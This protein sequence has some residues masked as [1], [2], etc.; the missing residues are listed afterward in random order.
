M[1]IKKITTPDWEK[2]LP[3]LTDR[4]DGSF[5]IKHY[6]RFDLIGLPGLMAV[7]DDA[8]L[9]VL[10]WSDGDGEIELLTLDAL[11]PGQGVGGTLIDAF[12]ADA[13]GSGVRRV[14]ATVTNDQLTAMKLLQRRGFRIDRV[15]RGA[16]DIAREAKP[17][18]PVIGESGIGHH[19]ELEFSCAL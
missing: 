7:R 3:L 13:R 1:A 11:A 9:G 15:R 18:I 4:W 17:R 14:L 5:I 12:M 2:L 19:D 6:T 10:T 8:L 16:V